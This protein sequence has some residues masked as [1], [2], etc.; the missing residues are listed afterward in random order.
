MAKDIGEA[1]RE[2]CLWF[3]ESEE[4]PSRGSP[5]FRVRNKTFASYIVNHHGDGN[6][7]LW[8]PSPPG[9]QE[10]YSE[11]E[12]N[13]YFVPPYVGPRGWLG[14]HLDQG[15]SWM[16]IASRVREAYAGRPADR[17]RRTHRVRS[18][19]RKTCTGSSGAVA[20]NLPVSTGNK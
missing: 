3:P 12:P 15:L 20:G 14:V 9:A 7:A 10:L 16:D 18:V 2:V 1:V 17:N 8:L 19:A 4:I 13:Y 5:D 6:I 11:A